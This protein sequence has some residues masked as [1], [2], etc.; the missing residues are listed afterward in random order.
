M[1]HGPRP[2]VGRLGVLRQIDAKPRQADPLPSK[3]G[4]VVGCAFEGGQPD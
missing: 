3:F 4:T 1:Q 2:V